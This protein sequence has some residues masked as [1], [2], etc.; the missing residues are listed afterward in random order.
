M[1]SSGCRAGDRVLFVSMTSH[2]IT[3]EKVCLIEAG[4]HPF[5]KHKTWIADDFARI[6]PLEAFIHLSDQGHLQMSHPVSPELL[7]R[8]R[9]GVSLSRWIKSECIELMIRQ[10]LLD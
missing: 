6:A 4:E 7:E 1:S 9:Q 8:I 5:V 10:G 3:K 2:D